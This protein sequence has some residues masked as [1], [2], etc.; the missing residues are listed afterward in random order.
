MERHESVPIILAKFFSERR[1]VNPY[2]SAAM[3]RSLDQVMRNQLANSLALA[4]AQWRQL[5]QE[6][7]RALHTPSRAQG[8]PDADALNQLR[9]LKAQA[10]AL[11]TLTAHIHALGA[12]ASDR[13]YHRLRNNETLLT[14]LIDLDRQLAENATAFDQILPQLT[15]ESWPVLEA[16]FHTHLE[17]IT[18]GLRLRAQLL[19]DI[20]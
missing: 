4:A 14:Q 20:V 19:T 16:D 6:Q 2:A 8:L 15:L 9:H 10:D 7:G 18:Q 3:M 5:Y 13:V 11:S 17:G 12:P 1:D